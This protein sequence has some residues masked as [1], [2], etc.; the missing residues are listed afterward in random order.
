[1]LHQSRHGSLAWFFDIR[2]P[3][4]GVFGHQMSLFS[5]FIYFFVYRGTISSILEDK[6][7]RKMSLFGPFGVWTSDQPCKC[8]LLEGYLPS[9]RCHQLAL[10]GRCVLGGSVLC[11]LWRRKELRKSQGGDGL[12]GFKRR[13]EAGA[14]RQAANWS[15]EL[16]LHLI[17]RLSE[18]ILNSAGAGHAH[19]REQDFCAGGRR[20][21]QQ[22]RRILVPCAMDLPT[23]SDPATHCNRCHL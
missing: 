6:F 22:S 3:L 7:E 20:R 12:N 8:L 15:P 16:G 10:A 13:S 2:S 18:Q 5:V 11:K 19:L 23:H 17:R 4:G 14:S 21:V 1:M 9:N